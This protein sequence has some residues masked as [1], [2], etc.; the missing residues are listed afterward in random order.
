MYALVHIE[1]ETQ[2]LNIFSTLQPLAI[3]SFANSFYWESVIYTRP[4]RME[5]PHRLHQFLLYKDLNVKEGWRVK[6][7]M[8][9]LFILVSNIK[10]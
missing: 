1:N 4:I 2:N 6:S 7:E 8:L 9:Q 10:L 5:I 3:N